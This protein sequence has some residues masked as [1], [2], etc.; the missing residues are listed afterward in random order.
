MSALSSSGQNRWSYFSL[1][2][3][4]IL[5]PLIRSG[6]GWARAERQGNCPGVLD[7]QYQVKLRVDSCAE[8]SSRT[9]K[10]PPTAFAW[11]R[12][13][14]GQNGSDYTIPIEYCLLSRPLAIQEGSSP[15]DNRS[16]ITR[17]TGGKYVW[18]ERRQVQISPA[19]QAEDRA[20]E[21]NPRTAEGLLRPTPSGD[22]LVQF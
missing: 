9:H 8:R 4:R 16:S 21:A 6:F 7:S 2:W 12:A 14:C 20:T 3:T 10:D 17:N 1:F 13:R 11:P 22:W 18:N 15:K 5:L 19:T